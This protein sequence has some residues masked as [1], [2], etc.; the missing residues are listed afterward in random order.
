MKIGF[1]GIWE[2]DALWP[3]L[4][5]G[6]QRSCER[7]DDGYTAGEL[8]QLCRSGNAFLCVVFDP[9]QD[10]VE[11]ASVWQFQTKDGRPVLR[12]LALFGRGMAEWLGGAREFIERIARENGAKWLV[13]KGRRGWL[14]LFPAVQCGE[15]YEVEL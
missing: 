14:R 13:T 10:R 12:C 1:A 2:V 15:D 5:E 7:V 11:M 8:W 4:S 6:F 9:E 3:R